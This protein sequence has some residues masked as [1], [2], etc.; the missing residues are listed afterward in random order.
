MLLSDPLCVV[1]LLGQSPAIAFH[2]HGQMKLQGF[3]DAA[4]SRFAD[5]KV[6]QRHV[7][8]NTL[9]E[10]FSEHWEVGA[11]ALDRC[12]QPL[13]LATYKDDLDVSFARVETLNDVEHGF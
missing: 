8:V 4:G 1:A 2:D 6:R 12:E 7:V 13:V 9:S 10:A 3:A 11:Q 5:E